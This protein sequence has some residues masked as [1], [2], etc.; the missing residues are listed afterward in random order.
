MESKVLAAVLAFVLLVGIGI[1][2]QLP[3]RASPVTLERVFTVTETSLERVA[4]TITQTVTVYREGMRTTVTVYGRET[5]ATVTA[6]VTITV[7]GRIGPSLYLLMP[8]ATYDCNRSTVYIAVAVANAGDEPATVD[9][10][11][12]STALEG[13]RETYRLVLHRTIFGLQTLPNQTTLQPGEHVFLNIEYVVTDFK[14]FSKYVTR[15]PRDFLLLNINL[16]I[17]YTWSGGSTAIVLLRV[18]LEVFGDCKSE[19]LR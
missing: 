8:G 9:F 10:G 3:R 11:S 12:V 17:P 14:E 16:T 13:V 6:T 7:T 5:T 1:G 4:E 18:L 19:F 2:W 15:G